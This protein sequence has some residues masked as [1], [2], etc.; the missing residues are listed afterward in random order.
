MKQM[1]KIGVIILALIM[2][3]STVF[4]AACTVESKPEPAAVTSTELELNREKYPVYHSF[5]DEGKRIYGIMCDAVSELREAKIGVYETEDEMNEAIDWVE[6][7][8]RQIVFEQP[9]LFWVDPYNYSF[10]TVSSGGEYT[11]VLCLSYLVEKD[12]LDAVRTVYDNKIAGIVEEAKSKYTLFDRVLYVH[13]E[14]LAN[15]EYDESLIEEEQTLLD[16]SAYGCVVSGKTVCSGYTLAFTSVMQKLGIEC[17]SEFNT[18]ESF[19]LLD[20]HVWNYCELDGE[21][22]YFDLTWDDTMMDSEEYK[23][24]LDYCHT[25]FGISA[26]E[27][28]MS[29]FTVRDDAPTPDCNGTAYNY[30]RYTGA[31]VES[32]DT[33]AVAEMIREQADNKYIA[34]RFDSYSELLEAETELMENGGIYEILTDT[35]SVSYVTSNSSLH[36]YIFIK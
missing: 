35:E 6:D 28:K 31:N 20:G 26:E 34:L 23:P 25:Y 16:Q 33:E 11:L 27:L 24:Y 5:D 19:S 13:D 10:R 7:N 2:L 21:Y 14:L 3:T 29:N 12:E 36:L 15:A 22:Y 17:G 18:Y 9:D 8:Y 1:K 32:Y 4:L 30:F